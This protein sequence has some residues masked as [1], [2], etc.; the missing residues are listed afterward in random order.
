GYDAREVVWSRQHRTGAQPRPRLENLA[1]QFPPA[2]PWQR[3]AT[4]DTGVFSQLSTVHSKRRRSRGD[5]TVRAF[6]RR[7]AAMISLSEVTT[8]TGR[9]SGSA[10]TSRM[11]NSSAVSPGLLNST[12][13][14]REFTSAIGESISAP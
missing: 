4:F 7:T 6:S 10:R 1:D 3:I 13:T 14:R 2:Q 8:A 9:P 11:I 12:R 5:A